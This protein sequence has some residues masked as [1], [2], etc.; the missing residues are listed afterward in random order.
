MVKQSGPNSKMAAWFAR[1]YGLSCFDVF[2]VPDPDGGCFMIFLIFLISRGIEKKRQTRVTQFLLA[3]V[4]QVFIFRVWS[5]CTRIVE[6]MR[7]AVLVRL[8]VS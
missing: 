6:N 5:H 8:G 1:G 3:S 4:L 7:G 2:C